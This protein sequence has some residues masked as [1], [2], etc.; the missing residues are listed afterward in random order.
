MTTLKD[1]PAQPHYSAVA[2]H[3]ALY[4]TLG[5][6]LEALLTRAFAVPEQDAALLVRDTFFDYGQGKQAPNARAWLIGSACKRANIY[7]QMRGLPPVNEADV[8]RHAARVLTYRDAME[9]LPSRAREA[10]RLRFQENKTYPEIAEE[11]GVS[12]Y[13]AERFVAKAFARLRGVLGG[14]GTKKP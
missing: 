6:Y 14:E 3:A 4:E 9:P 7:R 10:L 12:V 1:D 11:L 8:E 2:E 13:V 5:G